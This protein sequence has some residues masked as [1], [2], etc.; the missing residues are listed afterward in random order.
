MKGQ[1]EQE[2]VEEEVVEEEQEIIDEP[3]GLMARRT[4]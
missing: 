1:K 3:M 2:E 4:G